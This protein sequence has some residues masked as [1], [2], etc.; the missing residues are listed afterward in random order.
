[1]FLIFHILLFIYLSLFFCW[2]NSMF[3]Y[4]GCIY[5]RSNQFKWLIYFFVYLNPGEISAAIYEPINNNLSYY[6]HYYFKCA[7]IL[8][9]SPLLAVLEY[10]PYYSGYYG[11]QNPN[12]LPNTREVFSDHL[13]NW[14]ID[15]WNYIK[16]VNCN[17][18]WIFVQNWTLFFRFGI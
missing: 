5:K 15:G 11:W 2:L 8:V 14:L 18:R 4:V 16:L 12:N 3:L 9:R 7:C 13:L 6:H 10:F 17:F 1:M